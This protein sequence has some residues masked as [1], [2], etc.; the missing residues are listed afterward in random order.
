MSLLH[1]RTAGRNT[2]QKT[3][4]YSLST[5]PRVVKLPTTAD[6]QSEN[7]HVKLR[8]SQSPR[9]LV[10]SK[11]TKTREMTESLFFFV[12]AI[13]V[14]SCYTPYS[15]STKTPASTQTLDSQCLANGQTQVVVQVA[16]SQAS[17]APELYEELSWLGQKRV[18]KSSSEHAKGG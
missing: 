17:A 7:A 2:V 1:A 12:R 13:I 16:V 8:P 10:R 15:P 4:K 5:I 3:Q 14:I 9:S 18:R 11:E 6:R